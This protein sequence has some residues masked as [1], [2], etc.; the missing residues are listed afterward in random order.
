MNA[1]VI[2]A[3]IV[4]FASGATSAYF[5]F[6]RKVDDIVEDVR[7]DTRSV[8]KRRYKK[9]VDTDE[10]WVKPEKAYKDVTKDSV[11]GK[12]TDY[13]K[14]SKSHVDKE[15]KKKVKKENDIIEEEGDISL[16]TGIELITEEDYRANIEGDQEY[17]CEV[18]DFYCDEALLKDNYNT[19]IDF[20]EACSMIGNDIYEQ[21]QDFEEETI[22]VRNHS[23]YI[24]Y[25]IIR[26]PKEGEHYQN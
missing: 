13:T 25:K 23:Q 20:I 21:L 17:Y 22:Y 5:Y 7:E 12:K 15:E 19:T 3:F 9:A 14:Y 6:S 10:E 8:S 1:K 11:P 24:D 18:L 16:K 2:G 26:H 4:G